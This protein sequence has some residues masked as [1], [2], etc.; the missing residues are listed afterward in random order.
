MFQEYVKGEGEDDR[1][2]REGEENIEGRDEETEYYEGRPR[3]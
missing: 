2:E 1:G 3:E